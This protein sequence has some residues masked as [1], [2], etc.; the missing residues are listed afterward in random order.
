[1][2]G[3]FSIRFAIFMS[4]NPAAAEHFFQMFNV[5]EEEVIEETEK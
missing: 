5:K 4:E 1:M 3:I 2:M